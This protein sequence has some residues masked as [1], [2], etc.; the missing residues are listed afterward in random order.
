[1]GTSSSAHLP[2]E[3]RG[4]VPRVIDDVFSR[5]AAASVPSLTTP[6]VAPNVYTVTC[7]FLEVY[8][9]ELIDLLVSAGEKR[10]DELPTI[11]EHKRKDG[12]VE[13]DVKHA[14]KI[15]VKNREEALELLERGTKER[16]VGSTNMNEASSRSHAIFTVYISF[17]SATAAAAAG[18]DTTTTIAAAAATPVSN[19]R[20]GTSAAAATIAAAILSNEEEQGVMTAKFHFVDLAGSERLKKTMAQGEAAA[21]AL[22]L[23]SILLC[24]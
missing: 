22:L 17:K 24:W 20:P 21:R 19:T 23:L 2:E 11:T 4:I 5:I 1:M 13:I 10:S 3:E 18:D 15:E 12:S 9:D 8:G 16:S 7:S 6:S 14:R